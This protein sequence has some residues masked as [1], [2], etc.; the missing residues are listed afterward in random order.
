MGKK[1]YTVEFKNTMVSKMLGESSV[2]PT[3]LSEITGVSQSALFRWKRDALATTHSSMTSL[4]PDKKFQ[5]LVDARSLSGEHLG[6]FLRKNGLLQS[7]LDDWQAQLT[8]AL[9]PKVLQRS[10]QKNTSKVKELQKQNQRLSRELARKEKA[11]VEAAALLL[12]QK[13]V[14]E[15]W[16]DED[17]N[18]TAFKED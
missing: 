1:H 12:L 8:D 9:N 7:D 3:Q 11:L 14:R 18:T 17:E 16:G 15:I 5:L 4:S 10:R 2:S 6:A 13:K